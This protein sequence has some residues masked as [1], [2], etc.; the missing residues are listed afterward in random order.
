LKIPRIAFLYKKD[1]RRVV[2]V[3]GTDKTTAV[4]ATFKKTARF[5]SRH[6]IAFIRQEWNKDFRQL[7]IPRTDQQNPMC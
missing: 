7:Q 6:K 5:V 1:G 4:I 3:V 2:K